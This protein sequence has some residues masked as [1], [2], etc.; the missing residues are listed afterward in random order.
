[1]NAHIGLAVAVL[2]V[3]S[4]MGCGRTQ[5][6]RPPNPEEPNVAILAELMKSGLMAADEVCNEERSRGDRQRAVILLKGILE[7]AG[8]F[9]ASYGEPGAPP[10]DRHPMAHVPIE[11]IHEVILSPVATWCKD[12]T[13]EVR[14]DLDLAVC[15]TVHAQM[16]L[17][18]VDDCLVEPAREAS[19]QAPAK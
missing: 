18:A 3:C 2:G 5:A 10:F 11:K 6:Y 12:G 4:T 9:V 14:D 15:L 7:T 8:G 16:A 19:T 17:H 1:M 13:S